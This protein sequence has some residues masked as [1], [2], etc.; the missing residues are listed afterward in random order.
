MFDIILETASDVFIAVGSFVGVSLL[1]LGIIEYKTRG[2]FLDNFRKHKHLQV[3]FGTML[4]LAPG[5]GGAIM[6][7]PLYLKGHVTFG[8]MVA[9]LIATM[10]D[11]GFVLLVSAPMSMVWV[12]AVSAVA[13]LVTGYAIDYFNIGTDFIKKPYTEEQLEK[14]VQTPTM[15]KSL[16]NFNH[17]IAPYIFWALLLAAFPL[18]VMDLMQIDFNEDFAIK[19]LGVIGIAGT[20]FS[21]VYT[22]A[23]RKFLSEYTIPEEIDK[24]KSLKE[25]LIHNAQETAFIIMWIFIALLCYEFAVEFMGG[26]EV[27]ESFMRQTGYWAVLV[28]LLVGLIP[29]CGPHIILATLYVNGLLPFSALIANAICNDGDA[30]FPL[31]AMDRKASIWATVYSF[32]PAFIVGTI[33]YLFGM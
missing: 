13:A 23:T 6:V 1:L 33:F 21:V 12:M 2:A 29:G 16:Y 15:P 17:N 11:G 8:T 4:G 26:E 28:A 24:G 3:L 31:L 25:T 14:E 30:L 5:C 18:G 22:L 19:N 32:V 10:G 27:V 7:M 20:F 9:T